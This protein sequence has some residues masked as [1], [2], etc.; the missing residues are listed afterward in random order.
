M[1]TVGEQDTNMYSFVATYYLFFLNIYKDNA[2]FDF[3]QA[4]CLTTAQLPATQTR[5]TPPPMNIYVLWP[6]SPAS[7]ARNNSHQDS[8]PHQDVADEPPATQDGT[9]SPP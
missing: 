6:R 7:S 1:N 5:T 3:T 9:S 8:G 4:P 2:L